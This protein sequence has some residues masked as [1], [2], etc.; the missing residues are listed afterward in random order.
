MVNIV[1]KLQ[2]IVTKQVVIYLTLTH[3]KFFLID[4]NLDIW[5]DLAY[6]LSLIVVTHKSVVS[7]FTDKF[8][9]LIRNLEK[10][11]LNTSDLKQETS[12]LKTMFKNPIKKVGNDL[13]ENF[14]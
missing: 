1:F 13:Y 14:K 5:D 3:K 11:K 12:H 6:K 9:Y 4:K 7:T 8:N 2:K 10:F